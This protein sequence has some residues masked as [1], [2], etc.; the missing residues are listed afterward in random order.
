M[1]AVESGVTV[2]ICLQYAYVVCRESEIERRERER[3][4]KEGGRRGRKGAN[5]NKDDYISERGYCMRKCLL[6][7]KGGGVLIG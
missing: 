3:E 7:V 2:R 4:R 5:E 6:E 1:P